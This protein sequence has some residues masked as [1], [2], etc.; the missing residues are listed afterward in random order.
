MI[1]LNVG[2]LMEQQKLNKLKVKWRTKE[3][4]RFIKGREKLITE[5]ELQAFQSG[6]NM[7]WKIR[8]KINNG[9]LESE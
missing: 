7:A 5:E 1:C 6:F 8:N 4:R 3:I 2:V 9:I